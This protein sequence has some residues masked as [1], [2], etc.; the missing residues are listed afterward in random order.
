[1]CRNEASVKSIELSFDAGAEHHS[2]V[3]DSPKLQ[4]VFGNLIRNAIKFTPAGGRVAVGSKISPAGML[5]VTVSDTGVGI[6]QEVLPKVFQAFEQGRSAV[7][8]EYGGLGLGLAIC[9]GIVAAH[10]GTIS[11]ASEGKNK[12]TT[13]TVELPVSEPAPVAA[14]A[15]APRVDTSPSALKILL[16]EDHEDTLRAMARLLR[17]LEHSVTT[18]T[19][20]V[21]ALQAADK[22]QFDLVISDLGLPDG[23]GLELMRSM[24]ARRPCKGIALTGY[25]RESDIDSSREA[26][27][28]AHLTKP[29]NFQALANAIQMISR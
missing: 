12:G 8:R 26:G 22:D 20:V 23:T 18:A 13:M 27:F 10:H 21:D 5:Q 9:K 11:A 17:K 25:G 3:G 29:V 15:P 14:R 28:D 7:T 24:L 6:D 16:V 1:M 4:Q 19:C 2:V